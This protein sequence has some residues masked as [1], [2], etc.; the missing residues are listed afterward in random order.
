MRA[1]LKPTR[2]RYFSVGR[3]SHGLGAWHREDCGGQSRCRAC[4]NGSDDLTDSAQLVTPSTRRRHHIPLA[5]FSPGERNSPP[6]PATRRVVHRKCAGLRSHPQLTPRGTHLTLEASIERINRWYVGWSGYFAMT[7]YP[8]QLRK[9]EAHIRRRLRS[10]LVDQQKSRR[11]LFRKLVQRGVPRRQAAK[12]VF[13]NHRRWKL[14]NTFAVNRA[15][16]VGWFIG[17]MG[18]AIRSDKQLPHWFDVSQ[19]IRLT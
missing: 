5:F 6:S 1:G 12:A 3:A 15:F 16:P 10:R 13:S 18:Q 11:N 17:D 4:L 19:W 7:Y 2:E 14:S 9:I 8:A